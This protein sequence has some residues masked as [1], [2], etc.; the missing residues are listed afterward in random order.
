MKIII[1]GSR[2]IADKNLIKIV[3]KES[4]F[5]ITECVCGMAQ[6]V[7]LVG[8]EICLELKIPI[9]EFPA[10][11]NDL[12]ETPCYLKLNKFGKKY[13]SLAG[14]NRNKRM[15]EYAE[16]LILIWDGKS[17][18]SSNMLKLAKQKGLKIFEKI[19]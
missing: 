2:S 15:A 13:N 11:W 16:G 12:T 14:H 19:I 8:R 17:S 18:G 6:G 1:A 5:N 4:N 7:D 10:Q 9:K 3:I